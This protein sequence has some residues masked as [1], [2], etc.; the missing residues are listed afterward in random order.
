MPTNPAANRF[1]DFPS[2]PGADSVFVLNTG[3]KTIGGPTNFVTGVQFTAGNNQLILGPTETTIT[4][5][6]VTPA[7]SRTYTIPDIGVNGNFA[8]TQNGT[9]NWYE[10]LDL[11]S[12]IG[13]TFG[14]A[15]VGI[16]IAT[17]RVR[18]IRIERKVYIEGLIILSAKGSSTGIARIT[19]G[20]AYV[21]SSGILGN[22]GSGLTIAP[23]SVLF[24][25][26]S[27]TQLYGQIKAGTSNFNMFAFGNN[28][29]LLQLSD[30]NFVN[31]SQLSF[32]GFYS[33]GT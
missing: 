14:G 30:V 13:I 22:F 19:T 25:S 28:V 21:H 17:R 12:S 6:S 23:S 26:G 11:S 15:N 29:A 16:N 31:T 33:V 4:V 3:S 9:F 18:A 10:E 27:H 20:L 2:D 7:A 8:V 24:P 32:Q 1:I 5:S